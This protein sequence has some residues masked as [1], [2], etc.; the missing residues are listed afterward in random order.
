V[1]VIV[2]VIVTVIVTVTVIVIGQVDGDAEAGEGVDLA[3]GD[4]QSLGID[5]HLLDRGADGG[6]AGAGVEEGGEG[7]VAGDA[8]DTVEI[9]RSHAGSGERRRFIRDAA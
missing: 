9:E 7:H 4:L 5:A 8:T 1:V 3:G 2:I 6:F